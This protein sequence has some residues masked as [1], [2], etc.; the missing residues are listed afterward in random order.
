MGDAAS[1]EAAATAEQLESALL[2][3][4]E[5][6]AECGELLRRFALRLQKLRYCRQSL[7]KIPRCFVG[8][9]VS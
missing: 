3:L 1:G 8:C 4:S 5:L 7:V 6:E 9:L 2:G